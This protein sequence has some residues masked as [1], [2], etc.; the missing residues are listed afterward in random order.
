MT[1]QKRLQTDWAAVTLSRQGYAVVA[2]RTN[3][4]GRCTCFKDLDTLRQ[5]IEVREVRVRRWIANVPHRLCI[6]K[7]ITLP[8]TNIEE[9]VQMAE[10]ELPTV[11]PLPREELTYCC[12]LAT[13]QENNLTLWAHAIRLSAFYRHLEPLQAAGIHPDAVL[14]DTLALHR[15]FQDASGPETKHALIFAEHGKE[16]VLLAIQDRHLREVVCWNTQTG[17]AQT[18]TA[19]AINDVLQ[20]HVNGPADARAIQA[21]TT[22]LSASNVPAV[23]N[24]LEHACHQSPALE[25]HPAILPDPLAL[26]SPWN[27]EYGTRNDL[28]FACSVALGSLQEAESGTAESYRNLVPAQMRAEQQRQTRKRA[29]VQIAILASFIVLLGWACLWAMNHRLQR[30]ISLLEANMRPYAQIAGNIES[31]RLVVAAIDR[32]LRGRTQLLDV[33]RDIYQHLPES[34]YLT[35]MIYESRYGNASVD[36]KGYATKAETTL[37]IPGHMEAAALLNRVRLVQFSGEEMQ[38]DG[39]RSAPFALHGEIK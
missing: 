4:Q 33:M 39:S 2:T 7:R 37:D 38:Q 9:A 22:C 12:S 15:W 8:T 1:Q 26:C 21:C 29:V 35:Q 27:G 6:S 17:D 36:M 5:A 11:V 20:K 25:I 18:A 31:K 28:V 19:T 32:Q 14:L 23:H 30:Q 16:G 24:A 34:V 3:G 10:F 13:Q